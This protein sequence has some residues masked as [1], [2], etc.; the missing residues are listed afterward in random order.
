MFELAGPRR[1]LFKISTASTAQIILETGKLR[2]SRPGLFNDV[3][4][5]QFDLRTLENEEALQPKILDR[6]WQS[7]L[8]PDGFQPGNALGLLHKVAS[9]VIAGLGRE[10]FFTEMGPAVLEGIAKG[11]EGLPKF[12]EEIRAS[13]STTKLLCLTDDI[14]GRSLWGHYGD[15]GRGVALEFRNVESL[16]SPYRIAKA[17]EYLDLPPLL[18]DEEFL[19]GWMSGER[20]FTAAGL[21]DKTLFV[22]HTDWRWE[23]EWRLAS[24]DGRHA[25]DTFED[26]GFH[27]AELASIVLGPRACAETVSNMKTLANDRYFF[28]TVEKLVTGSAFQL[29]RVIDQPARLNFPEEELCK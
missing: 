3:F 25:N 12:F 11:K 15:S 10:T 14:F 19:L 28:A 24:G 9:P 26:A 8:D 17:V 16:D 6:L 20:A 22:K 5:S 1:A 23:R 27:H 29:T 18:Y 7:A 2:W 4:D 21:M 13:L